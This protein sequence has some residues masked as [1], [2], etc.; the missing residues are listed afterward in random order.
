LLE[1]LLATDAALRGWFTS[2]H[3]AWLDT[4]MLAFSDIG[5][6]GTAW[7]ILGTVATLENRRRGG[8]LWQLGLAILLA[9]V[10]VDLVLKPSIA[11]SRP[12][13]VL[14]DIRVVGA[15]P[16]TYSFP[17]GHACSSFAGAWVLTLMWVRVAPLIWALAAL[18]AFSRVYI[19][20]HYPIDVL[21]GA[22]IGVAV[23]ALVTGGRR[24]YLSPSAA[25]V[26][27]RR[28]RRDSP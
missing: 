8:R 9:Y 5:Q 10:L 18:I 21:A 19:G 3:A 17:S 20:V 23:G 26:G 7:F 14:M 13:D 12:Y 1:S 16:V 2:H 11:R 6:A 27:V 22:L 4:V 28:T 15:R 25:A 24:T